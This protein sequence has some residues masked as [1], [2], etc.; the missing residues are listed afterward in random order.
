VVSR[1]AL[2]PVQD[3]WGGLVL[4]DGTSEIST[5]AA[6]R[7]GLSA[8]S[9]LRWIAEAGP[10]MWAGAWSVTAREGK[11]RIEAPLTL[12]LTV[13][14]PLS[15]RL[16]LA[17]DTATL[18]GSAIAYDGYL[19]VETSWSRGGINLARHQPSLTGERAD[20][21]LPTLSSARLGIS[22]PMAAAWDIEDLESIAP[23]WDLWDVEEARI[24]DRIHVSSVSRASQSE[25]DRA[26]AATVAL[27]GQGRGRVS[28]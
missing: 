23:L 1:Y 14:A 24:I 16:G 19:P 2:A 5:F 21:G 22:T 10:A 18:F 13:T 27:S 20:I 12:E 3:G 4:D 8:A 15:T 25:H 9:I 11:V 7:Q 17:S 26:V 6:G 28:W